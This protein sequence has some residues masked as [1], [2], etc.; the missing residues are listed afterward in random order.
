MFVRRANRGA[1]P[2]AGVR[3]ID[4]LTAVGGQTELVERV[5]IEED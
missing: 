4:E 3:S 2:D 5:A 1:T